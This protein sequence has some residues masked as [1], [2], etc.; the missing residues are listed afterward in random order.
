MTYP[1]N[2]SHIGLS[3]PDLDK[4]VAFYTEIFGWYTLMEPSDVQNDDTPIGQMCRDVFGDDWESFRI[5]HLSTGDKIGIELFEFPQNEQPENNF[6]YWKTGIFHFCVQD[7]DI[8]G[9]VEKIKKHGGKQRMPIREYYPDDK[10]YKM[11]YVEDPFGN[12]FEIYT[13]SYELTYSQ[14]AY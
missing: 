8:E 6:E 11:V 3:V 7:P 14:G 5:A 2:F 9:L 10:P 4:A 13:H 12:I 1:R